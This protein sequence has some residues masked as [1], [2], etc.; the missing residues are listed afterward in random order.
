MGIFSSLFKPSELTKK[1]ASE[2]AQ[3]VAYNLYRGD[4]S[5]QW[6]IVNSDT[7]LKSLVKDSFPS[8]NISLEQLRQ[9]AKIVMEIST[10]DEEY[11]KYMDDLKNYID[12][13]ESYARPKGKSPTSFVL[14]DLSLF[15]D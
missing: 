13:P 14:D 10:H 4:F 2:V 12:Y 11:L 7:F 6:F 15:G 8:H 9:I 1:Q 3:G 5:W